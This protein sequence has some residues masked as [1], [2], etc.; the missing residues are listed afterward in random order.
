M[1]DF[2]FLVLLDDPRIRSFSWVRPWRW[3]RVLARWLI[4][5]FLALILGLSYVPWQQ[6]A[7]GDGRVIAA[8][9]TD[10]Q[11]SIDAPVD[12][13]LDGW[14]VQEGT[15]VKAGD[16]I[17]RIVDNDPDILSRLESETTTA[18]VRLKV[19]EQAL[20]TVRLNV[21]RQ[22]EL[23]NQGLSARKQYEDALLK[24]ADTM[25]E[26]TGARAALVQLGTRAARQGR[27]VVTAPRAGT[28][29]RRA[30][31]E[32]GVYVKTGETLAQLVPDTDSR[33]VE[34]M[35]D[36]NE[37]PLLQVG[38][39]V[40]L[41]FE[42]WPAIQFSGWPSIAVGTFR[43]EIA[44]ID[45]SDTGVPGQFR[46]LVSPP[47]DAPADTQVW[48]DTRYLRQGVRTHGWVLLNVVSLGYEVWRRFNDFPP[49]LPKEP[50]KKESSAPK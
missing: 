47:K 46:I 35:L 7:Y 1:S 38:Q 13:W 26:V 16:P 11:Q 23:F 17:V 10:R 43:G 9:P 40:R 27:Q 28:I 41:Q 45:A 33:V 34:L 31:G 49:A 2:R 22:K 37:L 8:S 32:S 15:Q 18:E 25:K 4:V 6:T 30:S 42:G 12:G 21:R 24:E 36:G 14:L 39:E 20:E 19:A 44:L 48:P 3:T 50:E 29:L 5:I